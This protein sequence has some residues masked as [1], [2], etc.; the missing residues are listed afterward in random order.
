MAKR[1]WILGGGLIGGGWAAAFAGAG[2]DVTVIDPDPAA[3]ARL[4]R[5]WQAAF[6][7]MERCGI[8]RPEKTPA[9][10]TDIV[11]APAD[12]DWVQENLPERLDLKRSALA[13]LEK[14]I[15]A[16]TIIASSSSGLSPDDMAEGLRHPGRLVIAHPCNPSYLMPVVEICGNSQISADVMDRAAAM[17]EA[18]GRI[19]LRLNKPMPGHLVNRLQAALWREAV[20]LAREGV[21]SLADIERAVVLGLAPRWT[22][23]GPS[24]VFHVSGGESGMAGFL[25]A[26]GPE[27]ER[28]WATLGTPQLDA[29]TRRL[30]VEGMAE[31]DPR[32]VSEI[33]A[34]RDAALPELL[35]FLREQKSRLSEDR[36]KGG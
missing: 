2:H 18:M 17:F 30:L 1:V 9:V 19:V 3:P 7:V 29:D 4:A 11:L 10:V 8:A 20:H 27:F 13:A 22:L 23:M 34:A 28:W 33:A 12:P 16:E 26:L 14:L 24:S 15:G 32:P 25:A 36:S 35:A 31:A 6:E 21:A 5:Q